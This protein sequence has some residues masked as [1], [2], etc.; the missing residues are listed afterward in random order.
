MVNRLLAGHMRNHGSPLASLLLI[1]L[2]TME[3]GIHI[4]QLSVAPLQYF[5]SSSIMPVRQNIHF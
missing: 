4:L 5:L 3:L 1:I 2:K